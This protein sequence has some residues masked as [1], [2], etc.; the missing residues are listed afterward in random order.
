MDIYLFVQQVHV[1]VHVRET[2]TAKEAWDT[3]RGQFARE[4]LL[5]KVRLRQQYYS[6]RFQNGDNMLEHISHL[7]SLHDQLKELG[8]NVDDKEL[9]MT[10]LAS[11][12]EKYKPLITA[13]D[14]VGEAQLSY[15]K[16]KNMILNDEDRASD[17]KL[18]KEHSEDAFSAQRGKFR[19]TRQ[20]GSTD[21]RSKYFQS[22]NTENRSKF[23]Q[24]K[25]HNCQEKGHFARDC[26]KEK[27]ENESSKTTKSNQTAR[28]AKE[29]GSESLH[30]DEALTSSSLNVCGKSDW[31]I[32]SG[33][34]QD[35]T[36][37]KDALVDYV[38]FKQPSIVNL[39]DNH[40]IL[41]YGKGTYRIKAVVDDHIQ[42]ISLRDVLYLPDLDKN[43]LSV[44]AMIKLGAVVSF[45]D[46]IAKFH[47]T[48]NFWLLVKFKENFTF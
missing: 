35:M 33:A 22:G 34:T 5:R 38:E 32:D 46:D 36:F 11:L 2:T 14:V 44:R 21:N 30:H 12:P 42:N 25:C 1:P 41:A 40:L 9:A 45:E 47:E 37:E 18:T 26:P 16:V 29:Q 13:L 39:G 3:L 19:N 24:G 4:S 15:E 48:R 23:F 43:L 8:V 31:I 20:H 17:T 7:K 27:T 6:C 10:L 28:C